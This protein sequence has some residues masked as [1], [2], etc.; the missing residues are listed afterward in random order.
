LVVHEPPT[1]ERV[2]ICKMFGI[3]RAREEAACR[4][5]TEVHSLMENVGCGRPFASTKST[6]AI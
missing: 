6:T 4:F 2:D 1:I 3:A 5:P